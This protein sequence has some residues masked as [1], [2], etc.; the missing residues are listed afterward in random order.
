MPTLSDDDAA[1]AVKALEH[2]DAYPTATRR[3]H[4]QY[5]ALAERRQRKPPEQ[6]TTTKSEKSEKSVVSYHRL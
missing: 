6:E 1:L 4:G 3:E 2:Y 5:K